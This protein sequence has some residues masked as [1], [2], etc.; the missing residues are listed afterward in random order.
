MRNEITKQDVEKTEK[1]PEKISQEIN[2]KQHSDNEKRLNNISKIESK[3]YS[4]SDIHE[5]KGLPTTSFNDKHAQNAERLE[6]QN[7]IASYTRIE[8]VKDGNEVNTYRM[9]NDYFA[10]VDAIKADS[11]M[12]ESEKVKAL[13]LLG[14]NVTEL[15]NDFRKSVE[16]NMNEP[17]TDEYRVRREFYESHNIINT[18]E[19]NITKS[20]V[21]EKESLG[22]ALFLFEQSHWEN[23]SVSEKKEAVDRLCDCIADDLGIK[24]KPEIRYY[25]G[26]I[27]ESGSYSRQE[28]A[29]YINANALDNGREVADTI[30]HESRHC[31]QHEC[32]ENPR[33]EQDYKFKENFENYV[34]PEYNY[35]LY[36]KQT[37]EQDAK[38]YA[39][40]ISEK[41]PS[42]TEAKSEKIRIEQTETHGMSY[43]EL[44]PERGAVFDKTE[45]PYDINAKLDYEKVG[46]TIHSGYQFNNVLRQSIY[47]DKRF[48]A[49]GI[50]RETLALYEKVENKTDINVCNN[51]KALIIND[52]ANGKREVNIAF[53]GFHG[54]DENKEI[55][56]FFNA[57][58]TCN[59]PEVFYRQGS[60]Y[61][62][63]LTTN[64][65][66][67]KR[68]ALAQLSVPY[69]ENPDAQHT[70][71]IDAEGYKKAVDIIKDADLSNTEDIKNRV[72]RLNDLIDHMNEKYGL[73]NEHISAN[74]LMEQREAYED[75][76]N[77]PETIKCKNNCDTA[78]GIC[79]TVAP[80]YIN[81]DPT[82]EKLYEG[83]A[84]QFNTPLNIKSFVAF[85]VIKEDVNDQK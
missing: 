55:K 51:P 68:P 80:M 53:H 82:N 46:K 36:C 50:I 28:N 40:D 69:A 33:N 76:Q 26:D 48:S 7:C 25:N 10:K 54:L 27:N 31:W 65:P 61:G 13:T 4:Q 2:A 15:N 45:L 85:S 72:G 71:H 81:D 37:V 64:M 49:N 66:D 32:A 73:T 14:E 78:Y 18:A 23:I 3:K 16:E 74:Y 83:G 30:A 17:Y 19:T 9:A 44:N 67:G 12:S 5:N 63:N 59:L 11:S 29:I 41:I 58:G 56:G 21:G 47:S 70:Y 42:Y 35:E 8:K 52:T 84:P 75:F 62:N 38:D 43:R 60:E 57:D 20:D 34:K 1:Q 22:S 77:D 79:G 24:E 6:K 39:A